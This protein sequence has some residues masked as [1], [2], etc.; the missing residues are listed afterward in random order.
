MLKALIAVSTINT[1]N[2]PNQPSWTNRPKNLFEIVRVD[3][4]ADAHLQRGANLAQKP[5]GGR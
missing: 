5:H 1:V 3:I 2:G 4:R